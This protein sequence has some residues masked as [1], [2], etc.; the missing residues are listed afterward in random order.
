MKKNYETFELAVVFLESKD[1]VRTSLQDGV[2]ME[3]DD[4]WN[5]GDWA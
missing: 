2:N 1:I 4:N 5:T 3:W